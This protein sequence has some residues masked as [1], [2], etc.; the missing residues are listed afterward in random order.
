MDA[1][2]NYFYNFMNSVFGYLWDVLV[3]I[4]NAIVGILDIP[5]YMSLFKSYKSDLSTG[6][7]IA[8]ILTHIILLLIFILLVYLIVRGLRV[9]F[10]FKVPVVEYEAMK[11]EVV[12]LKREIMKANYEKDKILAVFNLKYLNINAVYTEPGGTKNW[13]LI[14]SNFYCKIKTIKG[15]D[16][17]RP[18]KRGIG[19]IRQVFIVAFP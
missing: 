19:C 15:N 14:L 17:T 3:A 6:G 18:K 5:F 2:F 12:R 16:H 1:F 11:D 9:L 13:R 10:R 7:W 4:K 8:A